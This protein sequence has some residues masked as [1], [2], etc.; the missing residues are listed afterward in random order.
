LFFYSFFL[1][2]WLFLKVKKK[3]IYFA[4]TNP[5]SSGKVSPD[6]DS[7]RG[8]KEEKTFFRALW[9]ARFDQKV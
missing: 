8:R 6:P 4:A 2:S 1:N 7:G 9:R 3:N 5:V